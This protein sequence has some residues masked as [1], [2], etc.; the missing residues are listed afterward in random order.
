MSIGESKTEKVSADV[1]IIGGGLAAMV[2]AL[3]V[4]QFGCSVLLACKMK[5]GKSG[6]TL[7]AGANFAAVLPKAEAGCN[8]EF[9][10]IEDTYNEGWKI[11]DINL[12]RTLVQNAP[13]GLLF[14]EKHG[15][16]FMKRDGGFELNKPPGHSHARTVF[17][18][19]AGIPAKIRG[20]TITAPLRKALEKN[21]I[22][23]FDGINIF[24]LLINDGII[25]GVLGFH[26]KSLKIFQI[27]SHAVI[28]AGGGAGTLYTKNTN[29]VDLTGDSYTLAL[30]AG[31][32]LRDMEF[33]QFF[34]CLHRSLPRLVIYSPTLSCGGV[35]RDKDGNRFMKNYDSER[36]ELS[37]RDLVSQAIYREIKKGRGVEGSVYL[38]LTS[39]PSELFAFRF[40]DLMNAFQ[41]HGINLQKQWIK[42]SPAAHFFMGGCVIDTHCRTSVSG[43]FAAG[44][45]TGGLHGANRLSGNGLSEALVFGRIAGKEA[46]A[47]FLGK[48]KKALL[49]KSINSIFP[50]GMKTISESRIIEVRKKIKVLNWEKVGI[51]RDNTGLSEAIEELVNLKEYLE[52]GYPESIKGFNSYFEVRSML[53][54]SLAVAY[55]AT[56]RK[57]SRGAHFREDFPK[58]NPALEK[59]VTVTLDRNEMIAKF[60]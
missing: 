29:P 38:D 40:P 37:T 10:H 18:H 27:E 44:E 11:N 42:V 13:K 14:L 46:A 47:F 41:K 16:Q 39:I 32:Q 56:I 45:A 4:S 43:L 12:I 53:I 17:T 21:R 34:P 2:A 59:A 26:Q 30:E 50:L 51:V 8:N 6:A 5:V 7:M 52:Q 60:S 33:V 19:N 55:A 1:L 9:S 36:M 15:V 35:L 22:K 3:E 48:R 57:E 20:K 54:T 58:S 49:P 23:I 31:C 24:R 25:A 28:I